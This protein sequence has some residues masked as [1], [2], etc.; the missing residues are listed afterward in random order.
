M[1]LAYLILGAA[2]L[3]LGAFASYDLITHSGFNEVQHPTLGAWG[4]AGP[5]VGFTGLVFMKFQWR[6]FA[7]RALAVGVCIGVLIQTLGL[8]PYMQPRLLTPTSGDAGVGLNEILTGLLMLAGMG[9]FVAT[10]ITV[11]AARADNR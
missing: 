10:L 11:L 5:A 7:S 8:L 1:K 3:S 2:L 6:R 4:V 9:A